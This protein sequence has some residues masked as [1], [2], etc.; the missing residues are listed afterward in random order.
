M[1]PHSTPTIA[2]DCIFTAGARGKLHYLDKKNGKVVW[3]RDL[4]SSQIG[5]TALIYGYASSPLVYHDTIILPVG[6]ERA[7]R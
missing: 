1:A 6:P 5:G 2:G 7:T 3:S 4:L